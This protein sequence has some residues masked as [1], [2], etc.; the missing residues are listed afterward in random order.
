[1]M[2]V[3]AGEIRGCL[4]SSHDFLN[5]D[6]DRASRDMLTAVVENC[7]KLIQRAEAV[8]EKLS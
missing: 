2:F 1:M 7:R 4:E 3:T 5:H 6:S 8:R